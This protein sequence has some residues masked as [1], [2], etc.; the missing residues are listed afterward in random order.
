M[1]L[2]IAAAA[3][4]AAAFRDPQTPSLADVLAALVEADLPKQQ[5]ADLCSAVRSACRVLGK[6]PGEIPAE[7][8]LLGRALKRAMPAAVGMAPAR[9]ANVRSLLL[10]ALALSGCKVLPG[11]SLHP[12]TPA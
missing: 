9:W 7:A 6:E 2:T 12:L 4:G 1:T 11:R 8:G 10:K 3:A 5:K